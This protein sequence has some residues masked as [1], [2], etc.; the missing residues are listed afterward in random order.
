M[1]VASF[2]LSGRT[3]EAKMQSM[4]KQREKWLVDHPGAT[5]RLVV[6][7]QRKGDVGYW[8]DHHGI[9]YEVW[10]HGG[11]GQGEVWGVKGEGENG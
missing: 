5:V 6:N 4:L 11:P 1:T 7:P 9:A 3:F 2:A 10:P 8:L